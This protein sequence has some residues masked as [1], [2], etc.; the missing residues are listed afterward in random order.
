MEIYDLQGRLVY[1]PSSSNSFS[2]GEKE[3]IY[4]LSLRERVARRRRVRAFSSGERTRVRVKFLW[5]PDQLLPS[6]VYLIR[7]ITPDGFTAE[8]KVILL[9]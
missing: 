1:A 2:P 3:D 4:T 8:K 7:A 6:G 5:Y 9:R